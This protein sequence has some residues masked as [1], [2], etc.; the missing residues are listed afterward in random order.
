MIVTGNIWEKCSDC[1]RISEIAMAIH[2]A[3]KKRSGKISGIN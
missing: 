3:G 2:E 1:N